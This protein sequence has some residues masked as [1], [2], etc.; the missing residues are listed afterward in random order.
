MRHQKRGRKL[1]RDASHREALLRN[2]ARQVFEHQKIMTT[3]AKAKELRSVVEKVISLA[4]K[5]D[6]AS[7]RQALVILGNRELVH[8]VFEE[9]PARYENK[10]SGFTR[11]VKVGNRQG[12]NAPLVYLELI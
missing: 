9:M 2:L 1:K 12:D 10:I 8:R 11:I 7:R 5:N 6:L 3:E 4:K